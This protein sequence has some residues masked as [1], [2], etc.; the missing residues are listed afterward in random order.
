MGNQ[1][2]NIENHGKSWKK[3]REF[4]E[5]SWKVMEHHDKYG[6]SHDK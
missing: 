2:K 1:R 5:Q 3:S 4:I 6:K